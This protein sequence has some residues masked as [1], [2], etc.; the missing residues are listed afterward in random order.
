MTMDKSA[1]IQIQEFGSIPNLIEQVKSF[2]T[3]IPVAVIPSGIELTSLESY[4][5]NATR[6]RLNFSTTSIEDFFNYNELHDQVGASCFINAETMVAKSIFDLGTTETPGHKAN[7]AKLKMKKTSAFDAI[8]ERN[9]FKIDQKDAAEFIEDWSDNI[10]VFNDDGVPMTNI[11][12]AQSLR[13]LTIEAAR[14]I[15]SKVGN[16]SES[17]STIERIEAKNQETIPA[18]LVFKCETYNG[19]S[20]RELN[21]RVGVLTG[22]DRP[23][24]VFR[25][26]NIEKLQEEIADEFKLKVC[27]ESEALNLKTFIG[28]V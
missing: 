9:G 14:E 28:E 16:F 18:K 11:A 10:S 24:I 12:A 3:E 5:E 7:T 22:S 20:D 8:C 1:V 4:M 13:N 23:S 6:Y 25:I 21:V 19:L 27:E 15:N 2:G 26:I 17:M